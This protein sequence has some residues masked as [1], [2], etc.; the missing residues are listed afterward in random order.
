MQDLSGTGENDFDGGIRSGAWGAFQIYENKM[1]QRTEDAITALISSKS[2]FAN[3]HEEIAR[4][5]ERYVLIRNYIEFARAGHSKGYFPTAESYIQFAIMYDSD[6]ALGGYPRTD[7]HI[8]DIYTALSEVYGERALL[9]AGETLRNVE[10]ND[11]L[12]VVDHEKLGISRKSYMPLDTI[13]ALLSRDAS[14]KAYALGV[15][16]TGGLAGNTGEAFKDGQA[17][18]DAMVKKHG[19]A[20]VHQVVKQ[21]QA[22]PLGKKLARI[23]S[24]KF[25]DSTPREALFLMLPIEGDPAYDRRQARIE[26]LRAEQERQRDEAK[27]E[28]DKENI[29]R[30]RALS[31]EHYDQFTRAYRFA[32]EK[33]AK[34]KTPKFADMVLEAAGIWNYAVKSNNAHHSLSAAKG[35]SMRL[36][37]SMGLGKQARQNRRQM[38]QYIG[39]THSIWH[40]S[41]LSYLVPLEQIQQERIAAGRLSPENALDLSMTP[42]KRK[43]KVNLERATWHYEQLQGRLESE[44]GYRKVRMDFAIESSYMRWRRALDEYESGGMDRAAGWSQADAIG[45]RIMLDMIAARDQAIIADHFGLAKVN[46]R[47]GHGE[48]DPV[49]RFPLAELFVTAAAGLW[50]RFLIDGNTELVIPFRNCII[51]AGNIDIDGRVEYNSLF[52]FPYLEE[53]NEEALAPSPPMAIQRRLIASGEITPD[54]AINL[55][56]DLEVYTLLTEYY[57]KYRDMDRNILGKHYG[58]RPEQKE[59]KRQDVAAALAQLKAIQNKIDKI[60]AA[61]V[62]PSRFSNIKAPLIA[63]LIKPAEDKKPK[64]M[65]PKPQPQKL[66]IRPD[67]PTTTSPGDT[68]TTPDA[69]A[70]RGRGRTRPESLAKT[71][72]PK[73]E[74]SRPTEP[75]PRQPAPESPKP[76][77]VREVG[78]AQL[79]AFVQALKLA[80]DS[81]SA[82]LKVINQEREA[83]ELEPLENYTPAADLV[84]LAAGFWDDALTGTDARGTSNAMKAITKLNQVDR[85]LFTKLNT[86]LG[87]VY[88]K[89]RDENK[90]TPFSE[91]QKVDDP[92]AL[93]LRATRERYDLI[94]DYH[95]ERRERLANELNAAQKR[96]EGDQRDSHLRRLD[97]KAAASKE[98]E[99]KALAE[100]ELYDKKNSE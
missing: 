79:A 41:D 75:R 58:P 46:Q 30:Y 16:K 96:K 11:R 26:T 14:P 49:E 76:P 87:F 70:E 74:V 1:F 22:M 52:S 7:K 90:P 68:V 56:T 77:A 89:L 10:M 83:L 24:G 86:D 99:A 91:L 32:L 40:R 92:N 17:A 93:D 3:T 62:Q 35:A 71:D 61:N 69:P 39:F 9:K 64:T 50:N 18:Y 97:Q 45:R 60:D 4:D 80:R 34:R 42:R 2:N 78:K 95:Q 27:A 20:K 36:F 48:L 94:L 38:I 25:F 81:D 44:P 100:L 19:K 53:E 28:A 21:V 15:L 55:H 85:Q 98:K 12:W 82:A 59:R 73:P 37:N 8:E 54:Q 88:K 84:Q 29:I 6:L 43:I 57:N 31:E 23:A 63:R 67:R 65:I 5:Y 72:T 47:R 66:A 13:L 33:D 51:W